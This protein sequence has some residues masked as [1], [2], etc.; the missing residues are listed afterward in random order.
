MLLHFDESV[1]GVVRNRIRKRWP[2]MKSSHCCE[3]TAA[4]L[5]FRTHAHLLAT[6]ART[7]ELVR[8]ISD[9]AFRQRLVA[10]TH[11]PNANP[12]LILS[13]DAK[14]LPTNIVYSASLDGSGQ[15]LHA[16]VLEAA[17]IVAPDRL[18]GQNYPEGILVAVA[19]DLREQRERFRA[20]KPR[21]IWSWIDDSAGV[22]VELA[23]VGENE[24]VA[25]VKFNRHGDFLFGG[26]AFSGTT[27]G[28]LD[29]TFEPIARLL[30]A[31]E[32]DY[33]EDYEAPSTA[34][35]K[36]I[37]RD[38]EWDLGVYVDGVAVQ[39]WPKAI[40]FT[41]LDDSGSFAGRYVSSIDE[42]TYERFKKAMLAQRK[43]GCLNTEE[44]VRAVCL[45]AK[46]PLPPASGRAASD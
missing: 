40:G 27:R 31:V 30:S 23:Q 6:L 1:L 36:A 35:E 28:L 16:P 17:S 25:S 7:P 14:R 11:D 24:F 3:A 26:T 13:K 2:D 46:L 34:E 44:S 38:P 21:S 9:A 10:L 8:P 15:R 29:G 20:E 37:Q 43:W 32:P 12:F 33:A 18:E 5:G 42:G 22:D 4:A 19:L 41:R 45:A 39:V